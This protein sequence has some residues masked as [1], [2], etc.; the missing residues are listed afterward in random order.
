MTRVW[1]LWSA[2]VVAAVLFFGSAAAAY[3]ELVPYITGGSQAEVRLAFLASQPPD[4]GLSLQAQR[5]MLDDCVS[6]LFPL[7]KAPLGDQQ[8]RAK[9]NCLILSKTLTEESPIFSYAWFALALAQVVDGQTSEFQHSLAQSQLTTANQW[10]MASLRLR[11]AYQYWSSLPLTLQEQLG[12]DIIVLAYSN[13]GRQWLAQRYAADPAFA[14]DI[15]AN[16]E[17]APPNL[18]RAFIRAVS[19]QGAR[20]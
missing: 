13:N 1:G 16:L 11:L 18:Q 4:P 7:I 12:A 5:L 8:V 6:T 20:S 14:E 10:A 19:T 17:K 15:T 2:A 9:D 3:R